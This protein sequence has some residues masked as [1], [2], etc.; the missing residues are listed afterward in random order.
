MRSKIF[1]SYRRNDS[2]SATGRLQDALVQHFGDESVF[3]DVKDLVD[4]TKYRDAIEAAL[5]A[6]SVMLVVIGPRW[7]DARDAEGRRKLDL[8]GDIVRHEI[9]SAFARGIPVIPLLVEGA[10]LPREQDLPS[11]LRQ[12]R[13]HQARELEYERWAADSRELLRVLETRH[14][15]QRQQREIAPTRAAARDEHGGEVARTDRGASTPA[16][17]SEPAREARRRSATPWIVGTSL[18]CVGLTVI[19]VAGLAIYGASLER[20]E[21][22][23]RARGVLD[24]ANARVRFDDAARTTP[25]AVTPVSASVDVGALSMEFDPTHLADGWTYSPTAAVH[26]ELEGELRDAVGRDV[27]IVVRF[28]QENGPLLAAGP[29]DYV[30]RDPVTGALVAKTT[31]VRVAES[32]FDLSD[33]VTS[34]PYPA[35]N[36]IPTRYTT[37]YGLRAQACVL[38]DGVEVG[39]GAATPFVV[40]W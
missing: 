35:F 19:G 28:A 39:R 17:T 37:H 21:E 4:G 32:P 12:L 13:D 22:E 6:C 10:S 30:H 15:I 23:E 11:D 33:L 25:L 24:D 34:I 16:A 36:L 18:G 27:Q 26:F 31:P 8:E 2:P 40:I 1:V 29:G 38:L 9:R 14:G 20:K 5:G 3:V 7:V